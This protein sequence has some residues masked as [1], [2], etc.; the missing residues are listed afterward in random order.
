MA[1]GLPCPLI[2]LDRKWQFGTVALA[3]LRALGGEGVN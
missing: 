2:G 3:R 1:T